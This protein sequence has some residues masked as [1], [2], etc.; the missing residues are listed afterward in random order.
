WALHRLDPASGRPIQPPIP[1]AGPVQRL[2][3]T[4]DGRYLVGAVLGLHPEDRGPKPDASGTRLW[5]TASILGWETASGRAGPKVDVNAEC[6]AETALQ[7]PDTYLSL[8]P[9][10]KSVT[11]WVQR[12]SNRYEGMSFAV[13]GNEPPIRMGLPPLGPKASWVLHFRNNMRT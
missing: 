12:G 6:D 9:D 7:S 4:P 1:S 8:S 13:D 11:A 10:G 5:R 3:V 2:A